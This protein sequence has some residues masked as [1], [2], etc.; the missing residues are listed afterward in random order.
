MASTH[1]AM[2]LLEFPGGKNMLIDGGGYSDNTIFDIGARVV[3]PFLWSRK[4]LT[5]DTLVLTHPNSDHGQY[6]AAP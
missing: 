3:A 6:L 5:V 2:M 1:R 4:I